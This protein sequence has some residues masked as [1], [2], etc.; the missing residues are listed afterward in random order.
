MRRLREAAGTQFDPQVVQTFLR[1]PVDSLESHR[2]SVASVLA[3]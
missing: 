3:S 1:L 2:R